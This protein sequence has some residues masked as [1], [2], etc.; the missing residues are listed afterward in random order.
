MRLLA[1]LPPRPPQAVRMSDRSC[2]EEEEPDELKELETFV[3]D[4]A[5]TSYDTLAAAAQTSKLGGL[6][7]WEYDCCKRIYDS[8]FN[9]ETCKAV[10]AE[11]H[12]RGGLALMQKLYHVVIYLSP[13]AASVRPRNIAHTVLSINLD[14][15]GC[16]SH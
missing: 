15:V 10:G 13:L 11:L 4:N 5:F 9:L 1:V 6:E 8:S 14:G 2:S 16:W 12:Q 7:A 3:R